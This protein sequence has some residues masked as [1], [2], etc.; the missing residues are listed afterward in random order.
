MEDQT[1]A[2]GVSRDTGKTSVGGRPS[3]GKDVINKLM[4]GEAILK[5]FVEAAG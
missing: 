2:T 1:S 4:F 5:I 3:P